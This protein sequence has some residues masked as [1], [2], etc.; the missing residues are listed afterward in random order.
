[1]GEMRS[2]GV[3]RRRE[4]IQNDE[5]TLHDKNYQGKQITLGGQP[6]L[7][8]IKREERETWYHRYS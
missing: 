4:C 8:P 6:A 5:L 2:M 1:M 7:L 3:L